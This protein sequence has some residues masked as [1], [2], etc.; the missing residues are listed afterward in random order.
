L[1]EVIAAKEGK[2]LGD[3]TKGADKAWVLSTYK[4]CI[5]IVLDVRKWGA[6]SG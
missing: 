2:P 1:L 5:N 3:P 4:E 6:Y